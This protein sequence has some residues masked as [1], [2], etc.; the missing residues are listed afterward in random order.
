MVKAGNDICNALEAYANKALEQHKADANRALEQQ[1]DDMHKALQQQ[2]DEMHKVIQ[3]QHEALEQQ[4]TRLNKLE[5]Q[6]WE[7]KSGELQDDEASKK[8]ASELK[9]DVQEHRKSI[10]QLKEK[11]QKRTKVDSDV[12]RRLRALELQGPRRNLRSKKV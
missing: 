6:Q 12:N 11:L 9:E 4:G 8:I 2:R 1:N 7:W 3:Q 5:V 10:A